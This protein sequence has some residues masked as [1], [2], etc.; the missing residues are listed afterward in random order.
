M[1]LHREWQNQ[2]TNLNEPAW[3]RRLRADAVG[4]LLDSG[5][6]A[7]VHKAIAQWHRDRKICTASQPFLSTR[8]LAELGVTV[9]DLTEQWHAWPYEVQFAATGMSVSEALNRA[10]WQAGA[11]WQIPAG[12]RVPSQL[13]LMFLREPAPA[14]NLLIVACG[15]GSYGDFV[16]ACA[17]SKRPEGVLRCPRIEWHLGANSEVQFQSFQ[18]W[19]GAAENWEHT[20]WQLAAGAQLAWLEFHTACPDQPSQ[21]EILITG[22]GTKC[23]YTGLMLGG[24]PGQVPG[25]IKG[26]TTSRL[27]RYQAGAKGWLPPLMATPQRQGLL[28]CLRDLGASR[29]TANELLAREELKAFLGRLPDS[30]QVEFLAALEEYD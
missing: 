30:L 18:V 15:E 6:E 21:H 26:C 8:G 13:A 19:Q 23:Q 17:A 12:C 3:C 11:L 22:E 7:T 4:W 25:F 20:V 9:C 1:N 14:V 28:R 16:S 24:A 2:I 10:F 29:A 27:I 5:Y